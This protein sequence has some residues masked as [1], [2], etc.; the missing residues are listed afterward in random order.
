MI[1]R[2]MTPATA[3]PAMAPVLLEPLPLVPESPAGAPE[4]PGATEEV[5]V[6]LEEETPELAPAES[7]FVLRA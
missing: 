2:P 5:E 7:V 1:A 6:V 3:P 4:L